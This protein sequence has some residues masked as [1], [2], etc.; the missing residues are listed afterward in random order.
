MRR[1]NQQKFYFN[2]MVSNEFYT[3][4]K[5]AWGNM[6]NITNEVGNRKKRKPCRK[7]ILK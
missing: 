2:V 4:W 3:E 1:V 5:M 6:K 7:D